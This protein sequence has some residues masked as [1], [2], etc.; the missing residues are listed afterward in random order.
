MKCK[1]EGCDNRL[2]CKG[3]CN[4]HYQ[5]LQTHGD[6][7]K[8]VE[9]IRPICSITGCGKPNFNRSYCSTHHARF[10]RHGDPLHV[11][12]KCNRDGNAKTRSAVRV[13]KWKK[14]NWQEYKAYLATRKKRV[15]QATPS[16]A[17]LDAVKDFYMN[18]P[19][20]FHVDH[21]LPINGKNVSGLHIME[22]L[23]YLDAIENL[24]KSNKS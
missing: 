7:L 14:D 18:C 1:I 4:K 3:L 20:G 11:N 13:K 22:N 12:P 15:K 16:W 5:R 17:N 6:P 9:K 8:V 23:Q 21:I 10:R 24:K 19:K 2:L